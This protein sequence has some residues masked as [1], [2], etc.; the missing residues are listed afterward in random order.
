MLE[1][2]KSIR[3]GNEIY[4]RTKNPEDIKDAKEQEDQ[5]P[6]NI[7]RGTMPGWQETLRK[8]TARMNT[9]LRK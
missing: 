4:K 3:K 9:R 1:V 7:G 2:R 6:M 5:D 8:E